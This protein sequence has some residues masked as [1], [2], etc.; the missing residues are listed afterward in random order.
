M[1]ESHFIYLSDTTRSSRF[2]NIRCMRGTPECLMSI[3]D[4][5]R[6][7]TVSREKM[8]IDR[9]AKAALAKEETISL[10]ERTLFR[11]EE[12]HSHTVSRTCAHC[13]ILEKRDLPPFHT[14]VPIGTSGS[15]SSPRERGA[16]A[17]DVLGKNS[18]ACAFAEGGRVHGTR[19]F[20]LL[21]SLF[22]PLA[23]SL[24]LSLA[25]FLIISRCLTVLL[26]FR[27]CPSLSLSLSLS[28]S[29]P[30]PLSPS[31]SLSLPLSCRPH[32]PSLLLSLPFSLSLAPPQPHAG[33]PRWGRSY[34]SKP[35][36]FKLLLACLELYQ[37][38]MR[39]ASQGGG[40]AIRLS[41][42][43]FRAKPRGWKAQTLGPEPGED[44]RE[45]SRLFRD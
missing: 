44:R 1:N 10:H 23:G 15:K 17:G 35:S 45:A 31:V 3:A 43:P 22:L 32:P 24:A 18:Q 41:Q 40:G 9:S 14:G 34:Q 8:S 42:R 20:S 36:K 7:H 16:R 29:P 6:P 37:C 13:L 30:L 21:L 26:S 2:S 11:T 25:V 28:L 27:L 5:I 12:T 4:G 19:S 38:L 33:Q 39:M